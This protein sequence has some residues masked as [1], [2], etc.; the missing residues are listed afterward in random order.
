MS[1]L[2]VPTLVTH[3][4][5]DATDWNLTKPAV[6]LRSGVDRLATWPIRSQTQRKEEERSD[7]KSAT[8]PGLGGQGLMVLGSGGQR[9]RV[10]AVGSPKKNHFLNFGPERPVPEHTS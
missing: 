4:L 10:W 7:L 6:Q 9:V 8:T 5:T 1:F 2:N 3:C